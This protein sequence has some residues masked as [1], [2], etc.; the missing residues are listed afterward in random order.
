[1][2]PNK[3][4]RRFLLVLVAGMALF[5]TIPAQAQQ[6]QSAAAV[7]ESTADTLQEVMVTATRRTEAL[8][9]VPIAVS[10]YSGEK[11]ATAELRDPQLLA[12]TAPDVYYDQGTQTLLIRGIGSSPGGEGADNAVSVY[13]DGVYLSRSSVLESGFLDMQDVEILRGPQGTLYGRNATGGALLLVANKPTDDFEGYAKV[14]AGNYDS[15]YATGAISGP[16]AEG[17]DGRFAF[18]RTY[19]DGYVTNIYDNTKLSNLD[20]QA[21]RA[22]LAFRRIENLE[23]LLIADYYSQHQTGEAEKYITPQPAFAALGYPQ[24]TGRYLVSLNWPSAD[25]TRNDGLTAIATYNLGW[26]SLKSTTAYRKTAEYQSFDND[27]SDLSLIEY[28]TPDSSSSFQEDLQFNAKFG[29]LDLLAGGN[30]FH[31]ATQAYQY[32]Q[33]DKAGIII[34]NTDLGSGAFIVQNLYGRDRDR[35]LSA[36]FEGNY[37]VTS[38]LTLTVGGRYSHETRDALANGTL[39]SSVTLPD[40]GGV[41]DISSGLGTASGTW[42]DF[43]PE[44]RVSYKLTEAILAYISQTQGFKS[45]GI[46]SEST[47]LFQP[48]Y[49][50][51]YEGG[52]KAQWLDHHLT[53]NLAVFDTQYTHFQASTLVVVGGVPDF[54]TSNVGSS[55]IRGA[56][57]EGGAVVTSNLKLTGYVSF[58]DARYTN[59]PDENNNEPVN[60]AGNYLPLAPRRKAGGSVD[61]GFVPLPG[62]G[63]W[64]GRLGMN[65][66]VTW[67]SDMHGD[68]SNIDDVLPSFALVNARIDYQ[69]PSSGVT[70]SI[71]CRNC[72]DKYYFD[73]LLSNFSLFGPGV[74]SVREGEPRMVEG[75]VAYRF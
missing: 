44:Y 48:E 11:L 37:A 52:L 1:M 9:D 40:N 64:G 17:L 61:Y 3:C 39:D 13:Q 5:G 2:L 55:R 29:P 70:F 66:S 72:A 24:P 31:E 63:F 54:L 58:L 71:F 23:L 20:N 28:D 43:T 32:F 74:Y 14:A 56:E 18:Q 38:A 30:V 36:Y 41:I 75:Q 35:A 27:R 21:L 10:D 62:K 34:P 60:W 57:L 67:Q 42:H 59:Y 45:G 49:A 16:L 68:K 50:K 51:N 46:S 15:I 25:D 4:R 33:A 69:P 6:T 8:E 73:R 47:T 22:S 26:G 19:R 53:A 7:S 65:L 12:L